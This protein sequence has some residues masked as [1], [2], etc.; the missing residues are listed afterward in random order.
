VFWWRS[1]S[2]VTY[3]EGAGGCFDD[4]VGDGWHG[5][6]AEH[7]HGKQLIMDWARDQHHVL[8]WSVEEEFWVPGARLRERCEG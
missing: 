8:P 7:L 4:V 1:L 6:T 3:N 2:S 5:E